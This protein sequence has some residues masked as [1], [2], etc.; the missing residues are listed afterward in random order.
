MQCI[1]FVCACLLAATMPQAAGAQS[2]QQYSDGLVVV[3]A[4]K[5]ADP[6]GPIAFDVCAQLIRQEKVS[7]LEIHLNFWRATGG[8]M[9]Q[10][11]AVVLPELS[12]P[13]CQRV[14]LEGNAAE[15]RRWEISRFRYQP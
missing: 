8:I 10:A 13:R 1:L 4:K 5:V 6:E 3:T 15:L 9:A 12:A 14:A 7:P 11:S 2:Y